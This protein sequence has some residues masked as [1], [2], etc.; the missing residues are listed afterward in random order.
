MPQTTMTHLPDGYDGPL[1][2]VL[3]GSARRY[4]RRT[5]LRHE[6]EE[7]SFADLYGRACAVARTLR[8][9]GIRRGEVV[10]VHLGNGPAYPI[11]YY[12]ILLAGAT[13]TPLSPMLTDAEARRQLVDSRA[14]AVIAESGADG[15]ATR[16][17]AD[18]LTG[19]GVR[20]VLV[21]GGAPKC[22]PEAA[23]DSAGWVPLP[24]DTA[25]AP[26]DGGPTGDD[27]AHLVYTGGTTGTP[28]GVRVLHRNLT[29]QT[30][31]YACW[32]TGARPVA[33]GHGGIVLEPVGEPGDFLLHPGDLRVLTAAPLFHAMGLVGL[34]QHLA[35]GATLTTMRRFD[36]EAFL[37]H[38]E[39]YR[40]QHILG[41]PA[42]YAMLM[43][44]P[45]LATRDLTSVRALGCGSAPLPGAVVAR[46]EAAFP[47][48]RVCQSY[49]MTEATLV[50]TA[51]PYTA[52]TPGKPE[53]CGVPLPGTQVEIRSPQ[54]GRTVLPPGERG[55]V[56]V[57]GPQIADGYLGRP[58]ES[59]EAF[60]GGWLRTGD[61][62]HRD[63][64]GDLYITGRLKDMLIYKGYNVYPRELEELLLSHPQVA[65]AAVVGRP[66]PTSGELPVAFVVLR[67]PE[68]PDG[69]RSWVNGQVSPVKRLHEV[70]AVDRLPLSRVGKVLKTELL[71]RLPAPPDTSAR[72]VVRDE[73][74]VRT[75][76]LSRPGRLNAL[77]DTG[78]ARL[79]TALREAMDEPAV[80]VV[81]L[82]GE[83]ADFSAGGDLA[84]MT[85]DPEVARPRLE[86]VAELIRTI[87]QGRKPVIAA[88]EGRAYGLGLGLAAA[89][90][91]VVAAGD[92]AFC[93]PFARVGL[94]ADGGLHTTLAARVGLGRA[95]AMLLFGE[96]VDGE[97]ALGWGLVDRLCAPG[98]ALEEA[99]RR[100]RALLT[101]APLSLAATK[102]IL[103]G[104]VPDLDTCLSREAEA[105]A[106]L[107]A[108]EDFGEGVRAFLGKRS[109]EFHGR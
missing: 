96:V 19:T 1:T 35:S 7:V 54:D 37:D 106:R 69:V 31:Q 16:A 56:W 84:A 2:A 28:K 71:A 79:L 81:V 91:Q 83:G 98:T 63:G 11:A 55:E 33:D 4:G 60:V 87:T 107:V 5:A 14:V 9:H 68:D 41:A 36:R 48:A 23:A 34:S 22:A 45:T 13:A 88:V 80:R 92:S 25:E 32:R 46:L 99:L 72:I 90:D 76:V 67:R 21:R 10:A 12:G 15:R 20:L 27:V 95:K 65:S 42:M 57:H 101:S 8:E 30:L 78:R 43:E 109:P 59:A 18:L 40:I 24:E 74:A 17:A 64:D 102:Q 51:T 85:T 93:C 103:A 39:R 94:T 53:S 29:A 26:P 47:R 49:G 105:Q 61:L 38:V 66:D 100:A 75:L 58:R 97:S 104:G 62:G 6:G 70:H 73:D 44:S 52:A 82:T 77:D 108:S 3:A 89:C 86:A 50:V